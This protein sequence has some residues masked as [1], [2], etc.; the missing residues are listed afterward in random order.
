MYI[1]SPVLISPEIPCQTIHKAPETSG[2]TSLNTGWDVVDVPSIA[3]CLVAAWLFCL[4]LLSI[5][6]SLSLADISP[7]TSPRTHTSHICLLSLP[8]TTFLPFPIYGEYGLCC[9]HSVKEPPINQLINHSQFSVLPVSLNQLHL[10]TWSTLQKSQDIWN[11][12]W[13]LQTSY[14]P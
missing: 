11:T 9:L 4:L 14:T 7:S 6:I 10:I 13:E 3:S 5:W 12:W 1:K 8:L 2:H